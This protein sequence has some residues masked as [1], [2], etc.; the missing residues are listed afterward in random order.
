MVDLRTFLPKGVTLEKE[1]MSTL[2]RNGPKVGNAISIDLNYPL[3]AS[4]EIDYEFFQALDRLEKRGLVE[5]YPL[6]ENIRGAPGPEDY[7]E[8]RVYGIK[9]IPSRN[10]H[11]LRFYRT[12]TRR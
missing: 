1:I 6:I 9:T 3:S 12:L 2:I 7:Y 5:S 4:P 8:G 10:S 11:I